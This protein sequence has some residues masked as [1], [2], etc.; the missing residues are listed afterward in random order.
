VKRIKFSPTLGHLTNFLR[1][2]TNFFN[3]GKFVKIRE[4]FFAEV[5]NSGSMVSPTTPVTQRGPATPLAPSAPCGPRRPVPPVRPV[6]PVTPVAPMLNRGRHLYSAGRP[7]CWAPAHIL[8][9][10][11][12]VWKCIGWQWRNLFMPYLC[13]LFSR[14]HVGQSLRNVCYWH[15]VLSKIAHSLKP[16]DSVLFEQRDKYSPLNLARYAVLLPNIDTVL[17][18]WI[19]VTSFRPVYLQIR[20]WRPTV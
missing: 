13:R 7:S 10:S 15:H 3:L 4:F 12:V 18:P 16:T 14:Q 8:V 9:S 2:F 11:R 19:T 5:T 1:I 20:L 17:W 6:R